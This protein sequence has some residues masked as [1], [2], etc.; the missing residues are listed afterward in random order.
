MVARAP[1]LT[2][3]PLHRTIA[4]DGDVEI[5]SD[6]ECSVDDEDIA[7]E[8][9]GSAADMLQHATYW[10]HFLAYIDAKSVPW[11]EGDADTDEYR[12]QRAVEQ[13]NLGKPPPC[14]HLNSCSFSHP[15]HV[16]AAVQVAQDWK[17]LKPTVKSWVPH[18]SVFVAPRQ[19]LALGCPMNRSAD[20]CESFGARLKKVIK[21]L[22][23]RRRC[24]S[25]AEGAPIEHVHKR[26]VGED[27]KVWTQAFTKGYIGTAF[28]RVC[29]SAANLYTEESAPYRQRE[30][31]RVLAIGRVGKRRMEAKPEPARN[32]R[33]RMDAEEEK[34]ARDLEGGDGRE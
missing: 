16:L 33:A 5:D 25:D 10:D 30:D 28:T 8:E 21:H 20:S 3:T 4:D 26:T 22:T 15:H 19:I 13:F 11:A 24:R 27:K 7:A 18:I 31:A 1:A 23:C 32:L 34:K 12:K 6:S 9:G 29:V 14:H 2:L 17:A